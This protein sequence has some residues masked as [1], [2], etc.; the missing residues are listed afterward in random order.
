MTQTSSPWDGILLGDAANAPYS[1][2]EWAHLWALLQGAGSF[3]PNYGILQGTGDGTNDPLQVRQ[4]TVASTNVQVQIGAGLVNGKLYESN[5]S[6]LLAVGANA[7]GNARIDTVI[8]RTDYVAQTIRLIIKQGTPAASPARPTLTQSASLWEMPLA[9]IAVANGFGT[10]VQANITDRRRY[11]HSSA[12][13]WQPYAYPLN[14]IYNA[15]YNANVISLGTTDYAFP[16]AIHGNML[17]QQLQLRS[18]TTGSVIV[19][20]GIFTETLNDLG[21]SDGTVNL[22]GGLQ[23][24][25][26]IAVVSGNN[27]IFPV[28]APFVLAPG[29]YWLI[30]TS[31]SAFNT[32]SI[33]PTTFEGSVNNIL[34]NPSGAFASSFNISTWAQSP[35]SIAARIDGRVLGKAVAF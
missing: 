22:I 35:L 9:D 5:A 12:A 26:L 7:S 13:G 24:A 3:F 23:T 14:F 18:A 31:Q 15:A 1:S 8:L 28:D 16:I 17:V 32:F 10:I 27:A 6:E 21:A 19:Q 29:H 20:W 30:V 2:N 25:G 11:I 33:T 34:T 4:T